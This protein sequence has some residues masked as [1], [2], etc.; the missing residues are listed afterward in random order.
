MN[1]VFV[2]GGVCSGIGKGI[3]AAS[4]GRLLQKQ[5][6]KVNVIKFDPYFLESPDSLNPNEHGEAF[7]L[8][9][10]TVCDLDLGHYKRF[11]PNLETNYRS[12]Q[13]SGKIYKKVIED[14]ANGKHKGKTTQLVP[15][16]SNEIIERFQ[17]FDTPESRQFNNNVT[18]IEIG[19]TVGDMESDI[20]LEA[21]KQFKREHDNAIVIHL[22]LLPFIEQS[23]ELK[24]KPIQ[25]SVSE[26]QRR[27]VVP[28]ILVCRN[29]AGITDDERRKLSIFCNVPEAYI[30]DD[31]DCPVYDVCEYLASQNII[32]KIYKKLGISRDIQMVNYKI[33]FP[34][35]LPLG[36]VFRNKQVAVI[37]KYFKNIDAYK[38]ILE[39]LK[40]QQLVTGIPVDPSII[41]SNQ[42]TEDN[43]KIVL[44][45]YDAIVIPGGFGT[46][47]IEGKELAAKYALENKVPC[48]GI[49]LGFQI[50]CLMYARLN[51]LKVYHEE[52]D[53]YENRDLLL[54]KL[55]NDQHGKELSAQTM[56]LGKYGFNIDNDSKLYNIYNSNYVE[57][58]CRYRYEFNNDYKEKLEK[59]GM[60]FPAKW[61]N[62]N[63]MTACE[64]KDHPFYI[65]VQYHP[66]LST[67]IEHPEE[68]FVALIKAI[69]EKKVNTSESTSN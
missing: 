14:S 28:D 64:V 11:I 4:I 67:T 12:S 48:L 55:Q 65:G 24:T 36:Q 51:G 30:I 52:F 29:K 5:G 63:V 61:M 27:G 46:S 50:M 56:R 69:D 34:L 68:L 44:K 58:I 2:L 18:I 23:G 57:R 39:S 49:C 45:N 1:Y 20:Y 19:G 17:A 38:S 25:H 8:D 54:I 41:D 37:G 15:H 53:Q 40:L 31:K 22:G 16:V 33:D 42:L 21:I 9:D 6:F 62:E 59:L 26:L 3:V 35:D 66:E 7:V 32:Q 43:Y 13:T 47:G 60:N 10:G